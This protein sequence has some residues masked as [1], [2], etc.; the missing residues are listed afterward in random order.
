MHIH[1]TY[2][3]V[4]LPPLSASYKSLPIWIPGHTCQTVFVGL[5]HFRSQLTS[6]EMKGVNKNKTNWLWSLQNILGP[7]EKFDG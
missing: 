2:T 4:E 6:L 5:A 7:A 1:I 3:L